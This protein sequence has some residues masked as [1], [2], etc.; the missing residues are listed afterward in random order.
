MAGYFF[1]VSSPLGRYMSVSYT[2]L[3]KPGAVV[4]DVGVNRDPETGKLCGD[5]DFAACEPVA[6]MITKVPGGVGPMTITILL[7]NTIEA[8]ERRMRG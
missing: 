5:V 4:I 7:E 1:V 2:H 6:G 3:V 8:F